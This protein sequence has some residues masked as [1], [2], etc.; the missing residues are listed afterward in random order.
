MIKWLCLMTALIFTLTACGRKQ[1]Q[2]Q[3]RSAVNSES[4]IEQPPLEDD[5][6]VPWAPTGLVA[7]A[8]GPRQ[9]NLRWNQQ[10]NVT[11]FSLSR[12]FSGQA[13]QVIANPLGTDSQYVDNVPIS[14]STYTYRLVANNAHGASPKSEEASATTSDDLYQPP[15]DPQPTSH[16][17]TPDPVIDFFQASAP[18]FYPSAPVVLT[19]KVRYASACTLTDVGAVYDSGAY[20]IVTLPA[21]KTYVLRCRN[22]VNRVATRSLAIGVSPSPLPQ[23]AITANGVAGTFLKD[24]SQS[25]VI[26]VVANNV[27]SCSVEGDKASGTN[28]SF[29]LTNSKVKATKLFTANCVTSSGGNISASVNVVV[30]SLTKEME[31]SSVNYAYTTCSLPEGATITKAKVVDQYSTLGCSEDWSYGFSS[32]KLWVNLGCRANFKITYTP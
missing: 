6:S 12:S 7:T 29:T 13:F 28:F 31:C 32:N 4:G 26:A 14:D 16:P 18:E 20:T 10:S 22:Q 17:S 2:I 25:V 5:S 23:V 15:S 11:S 9:V 19:W 24:V 1:V 3:S 27:Q 30:P 8:N 21:P